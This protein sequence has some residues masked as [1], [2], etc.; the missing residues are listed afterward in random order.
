MGRHPLVIEAMTG[1]MNYNDRKY[2]TLGAT[3]KLAEFQ[4]T[5]ANRDIV[6]RQ[7]QLAPQLLTMA[8]LVK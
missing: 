6:I 8:T 4:K 1:Q 2:P 5:V 3:E 7:A